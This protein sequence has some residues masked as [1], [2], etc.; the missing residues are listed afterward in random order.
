MAMR[1]KSQGALHIRY[2]IVSSVSL[3]GPTIGRIDLGLLS[4]L[5]IGFDLLFIDLILASFILLDVI[6]KQNFRPFTY[7]LMAYGTV[8]VGNLTFA[9]TDAWHSIALILY[10]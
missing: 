8:H 9:N 7:G 6:K 10:P 1:N 4:D 3:F 5:N 2:I